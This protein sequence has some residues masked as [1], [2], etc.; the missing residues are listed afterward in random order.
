[1]IIISGSRRP[2]GPFSI[3]VKRQATQIFQ[4]ERTQPRMPVCLCEGGGGVARIFD[5][6]FVVS[7]MVSISRVNRGSHGG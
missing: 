4:F 2:T 6:S 5:A 7:R 1:M 3:N